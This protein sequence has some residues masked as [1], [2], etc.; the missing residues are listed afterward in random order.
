MTRAYRTA[1]MVLA[2]IGPLAAQT[3]V[4]WT[5]GSPAGTNLPPGQQP[6]QLQGVGIEEHLDRPI[7]LNLTFTAENGYPVKLADYFHKGRP[8]ILDL[9][10]YTCPMLCTLVL[11]SQTEAMRQMPWTPGN[12]YEVVTI[13]I[14]P[15]DSFDIARKKKAIYLSSYD[16]P[17][18]GWH[19]LVDRDGNVQKLAEMVGF[20]YRFDPKIQQ[21]AHPAAIMVLTPEGKMARYLYGV[22]FSPRDLRFA[23]TEASEG[24]SSLSIEKILLYCYH[25]DPASGSYVLFAENL[26][27]FGGFVTV[28]VLG[29]FVYRLVRMERQRALA[30]RKAAGMKEGLA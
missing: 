30:I 28:L 20:H 12:E 4:P 9:V 24:R 14:D 3:H 5:P 25:Y 8:V 18:G 29:F 7:D 23:L 1:M 17:A 27:R 2:A 19:F 6:A 26:M 11:N 16:R 15:N 22:H 10:Y 13:S 21:F